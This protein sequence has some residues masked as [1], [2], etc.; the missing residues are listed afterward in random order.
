[1]KDAELLKL[2][3]NIGKLKTTVRAGWLRCGVPDPE[4]VAEHAFRAAF[5][6]MIYGEILKLDTCKLLKMALLHDL[7]EAKIG[8][9]TPHDG[10]T[11]EEKRSLEEAAVKELLNKIPNGAEYIALW[12]EYD[13]QKSTEAKVL[14]NLDKLEMAL[15]AC[16]YQQTFPE[17]DLSEFLKDVEKQLNIDK[18]REIFKMIKK[19]EL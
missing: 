19:I 5:M 13:Q 6:A 2:F 11:I 15:Q 17:K 12:L 18:V 9:I 1:M 16:E 7:A 4:S 3:H 14:K 8:D 10:L